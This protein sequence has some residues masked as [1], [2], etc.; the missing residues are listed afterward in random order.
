[1]RVEFAMQLL[2]LIGCRQI[3]VANNKL[4]ATCPFEHEHRSGKDSHPSFVVFS[5]EKE[6]STWY[7]SYPH[8]TPEMRRG[9]MERLAELISDVK[10]WPTTTVPWG[11]WE[12]P[13]PSL[14]AL[15][16]FVWTH[17]RTSTNK[18][19]AVIINKVKN[20][21]WD[22]AATHRNLYTKDSSAYE[23]PDDPALPRKYLEQFEYPEGAAWR[24]LTETR[25]LT[26][27]T[28]DHWELLYCPRWKYIA[29][30][31]YNL[32]GEL[33]SV[34]RRAL[35]PDQ[36]PK[37][38]HAK[39]F[40]RRNHLFG[41]N[42]QARAPTKPKSRGIIVEGQFDV[43]RLWQY[44][45]RNAV[46]IF[47]ADMTPTQL[48]LCSTLFSSVVILTDGDAAGRKAGEKIK[49]QLDAMKTPVPA[50]IVAMP[51]NLDPGDLGFTKA[52]AIELLGAPEV[53]SNKF[54]W[55]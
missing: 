36:V 45:Y 51:D 7:C 9:T 15:Y 22:P 29:I 35:F 46:A 55:E 30:P 37:Y 20:T 3:K 17:D 48:T 1:M 39:G 54:P 14:N 11:T 38:H 44:G 21:P 43:I 2:E 6:E 33:V 18:A 28:I 31:V 13:G 4:L 16:K 34:S 8:A 52:M 27:E 32:S 40:K 26:K 50:T 47:G 12:D 5:D 25:G 41:E 23:E 24:Y 10:G 42:P 53:D 19:A 49:E